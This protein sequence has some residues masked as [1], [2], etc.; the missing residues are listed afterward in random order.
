MLIGREA[1]T[2]EPRTEKATTGGPNTSSVGI[3][4]G[5]TLLTVKYDWSHLCA[6]ER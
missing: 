2:A 6:E 1:M 3:I 4:I 5:G